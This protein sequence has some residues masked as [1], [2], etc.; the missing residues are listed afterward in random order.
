MFNSVKKGLNAFAKSIYPCQPAQSAD[1]GRCFSQMTWVAMIKYS[2]CQR[3]MPPHDLIGSM[4]QM[5]F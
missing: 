1:M 3:T 2:A 5:N 4:T